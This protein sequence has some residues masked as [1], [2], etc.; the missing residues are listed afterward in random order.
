MPFLVNHKT[1]KRKYEAKDT[2]TKG[3]QVELK[4][5]KKKWWTKGIDKE[6]SSDSEVESSNEDTETRGKYYS[7]DEEEEE[8]P[9]QKRL[10]LAKKY[11]SELEDEEAEK[12]DD[13]DDLD[14]KEAVSSRLKHDIAEQAGKLV[15]EAADT[16]S[17]P[18]PEELRVFRGH[19]LPVT[20]IVISS[21]DKFVFTAGKDCNICKW[22][23]SS[24]K[25]LHTI[26]G[27]RKGTEDT[28]VGHTDHILCLALS[29]DQR[30]LAAGDMT[31]S[32]KIWSPDTCAFIHK[33]QGHRG[34]VTGLTF[35]EGS[36]DL[37]SC[38]T[39]RAVKLWIVSDRAYIDTLYGH[40]TQ[41]TSIDS[42]SKERAITSGGRDHSIHIWK[43]P[44]DSQL[45]FRGTGGS[46]EC[47]ALVN[48]GYFFSG[49]DDS[50]LSLWNVLKK[51][52]LVTVPQAHG[53]PHSQDWVTA[54]AA[55]HHSNLLASGS[56]DGFVKL[57]KCGENFK[58]LKLLFEVPVKGFVNSL[59][60]SKNGSF[61]VCGVGQEHR[62]GRWWR[63]KEARNGWVII[64][65]REAVEASNSSS[66]ED[67]EEEGEVQQNGDQEKK[68][69]EESSSEEDSENENKSNNLK[70]RKTENRSENYRHNN[71]L[72]HD[73]F[74]V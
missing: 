12:K 6:I 34:P 27:G 31:H 36:H 23:V 47:V 50:S 33:F 17:C 69:E 54:V 68:S 37:Y 53:A 74:F 25:K 16:C 49:S 52:P 32:I 8:T 48:E 9:Q 40:D 30:Y 43:I 58:S 65:L 7:S 10:R 39:D 26:K 38:S 29:T 72:E 64:P 62:L 45:L 21:D 18:K 66:E 44:E 14:V 1:K 67:E 41:I 24:G 2:K 3:K 57:W 51:K 46:I 20:A 22:D 35:R 63:I 61:L 42:L 59:K 73:D 70:R 60:F 19:K 55:L 56:K 4:K 5:R 71:D 15:K 28:H 11:L 13:D